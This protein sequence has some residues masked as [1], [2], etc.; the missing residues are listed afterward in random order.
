MSDKIEY[1]TCP[2]CD[3]ELKE[4]HTFCSNC[5]QENKA[6]KIDFKHL[7]SEVFGT[8]LDMDSKLFK[9]IVP[10]FFK[11][12]FLT[13][14]FLE[15]KRASYIP[16]IRLYIVISILYFFIQSLDSGFNIKNELISDQ[17]D[18]DIILGTDTIT[19]SS[20]A[21]FIEAV[22]SHGL[23]EY[24]DSIG[25]KSAFSKFTIAQGYKVAQNNGQ[26]LIDEYLS[27][28]SI[29]MFFLLP[30][31]ALLLKLFF[32]KQKYYYNE[33]LIFS[34]HLHAFIF[35]LLSISS[36]IAIFLMKWYVFLSVV[37]IVFLYSIIATKRVYKYS[38]KSSVG[39]LILLLSIYNI[40]LV[41]GL[42]L[43]MLVSFALY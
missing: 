20:S 25:A 17:S 5:G 37:I 14:R 28:V 33:H 34:F 18:I 41:I 32:N 36:L 16:P 9:S 8:Y 39:R 6:L 11:P 19:Y 23:K 35:L 29:L 2:N 10:L 27:N 22:D 15:G 4:D 26:G 30:I 42:I 1:G 38:Y 31:F 12:G 40:I 21:E 43:T 24:M 13:L 3:Y 7:L